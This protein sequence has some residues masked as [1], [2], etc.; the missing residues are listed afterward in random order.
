VGTHPACQ[1]RGLLAKVL[2]ANVP[3]LVDD[4][5][6]NTGDA[7]IGGPRDQPEASNHISVDHLI[8]FSARCV[9]A[10]SRQDFEIV[11]VV[12][13]TFDFYSLILEV[14]TIQNRM[15]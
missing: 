9:R 5:G 12:R 6:H 3:L 4:K 1:L 2:L 14:R 10:L 7:V 13:P 11:T 15:E 8:V